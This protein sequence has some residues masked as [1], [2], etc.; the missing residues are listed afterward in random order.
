M[1]E[2]ESTLEKRQHC[3]E[4]T[5][6]GERHTREKLEWHKTVKKLKNVQKTPHKASKRAKWSNKLLLLENIS[7]LFDCTWWVYPTVIFV[8]TYGM[9]CAQ[10]KTFCQNV[11]LVPQL[12][13]IKYS[14]HCDPAICFLNHTVEGTW[15]DHTKQVLWTKYMTVKRLIATNWKDAF[16]DGL[17]LLET[18]TF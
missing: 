8:G 6:T 14:V 3:I 12:K 16:G 9:I 13:I 1:H 2:A 11:T 4:I 10:V 5:Q 15:S 18:I 17:L 7:P